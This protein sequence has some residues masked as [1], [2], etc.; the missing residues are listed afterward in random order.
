M[1]DLSSRLLEYLPDPNTVKGGIG[2]IVETM[3]EEAPLLVEEL[4]RWKMTVSLIQFGV[5]IVCL[6]ILIKSFLFIRKHWDDSDVSDAVGV[7]LCIC[8]MVAPTVGVLALLGGGLTWIKIWVAPK[9]YLLEYVQD[10][11]T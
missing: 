3:Q 4:L 1:N 5:V 11:L 6:I 7:H 8:S 9:L 10:L 2:E